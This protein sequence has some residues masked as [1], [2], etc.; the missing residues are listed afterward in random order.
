MCAT[1][2]DRRAP[3]VA[4]LSLVLSRA[5]ALGHT[6]RT[7][8]MAVAAVAPDTIASRITSTAIL[9]AMMM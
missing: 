2:R 9:K 3:G 6:R 7:T 8:C 5:A 4:R 1:L